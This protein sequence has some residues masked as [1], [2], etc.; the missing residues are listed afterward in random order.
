MP[1]KMDSYNK[2]QWWR[3]GI[4]Y[5]IY[6]LSFKDTN[7]DGFGDLDGI[8]EK[9]DYLKDLGIKGIWLSPFYESPLENDFGYG[10]AN[11]HE[12]N[13]IFGDMNDFDNMLDKA[14]KL[15][16]KVIIDFPVTNTS[17]QHPWFLESKSSRNNSKADWYIWV[18]EIPNNWVAAIGGSAWH[19]CSKRNQYY[20]G[21][22]FK[23]HAALNWRNHKLKKAVF[24]EMEFWLKKAIDGF[25]LDTVSMYIKDKYLRDNPPRD[26]GPKELEQWIDS[27][28]P[29]FEDPILKSKYLKYLLPDFIKYY[30]IYDRDQPE[31]LKIVQDMKKLC[32]KYEDI[33]IIGEVDV[34]SKMGEELCRSGLSA[35]KNFSLLDTKWGAKNFCKTLDKE[36]KL[37]NEDICVNTFSNHDVARAITR[38]KNNREETIKRAKVLAA[39]VFTLKG[40]PLI[41]YGEEIGMRNVDIPKDELK[42]PIGIRYYYIPGAG[43]DGGR[44]PMQWDDASY[45]GF[46]KAKP[47]L[48]VAG[49]YKFTNVKFE[50][51]D[52]NSM[53][54]FYKK[55][56]ALRNSTPALQVGDYELLEK[57]PDS[58]LVYLRKYGSEKYLIILNFENKKCEFN[59]KK[60]GFDSSKFERV[61]KLYDESSKIGNIFEIE[62]YDIIILKSRY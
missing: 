37:L 10:V 11:Y 12:I 32:N 61:I 25:R 6:P 31:T 17:I 15:D 21:L 4:I 18:D 43:R 24:D 53:L 33:F 28:D 35:A 60:Y 41:Y 14:H 3:K 13:P 19:Y 45:S 16:I 49:D 40:I 48:R 2:I 57:N 58:Y 30:Y 34:N 1:E 20:L 59:F 8:S 47:W 50:E 36:E 62:P 51:N 52:K 54:N 39:L 27:E 7:D 46:S 5:Q 38:Y 55:M 22:F 29:I 56:I 42:D 44:T 26:V 9:L 23:E